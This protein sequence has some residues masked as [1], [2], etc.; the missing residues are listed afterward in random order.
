MLN[1]ANLPAHSV[2]YPYIVAHY[3]AKGI[4]CF[5]GNYT[6]YDIAESVAKSINGIVFRQK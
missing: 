1:I 5:W 4:L 6:S 2:N 3:N